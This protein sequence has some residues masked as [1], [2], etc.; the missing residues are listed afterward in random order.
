MSNL[1]PIYVYLIQNLETSRYKIG[2][3]KNPSKRIK[4]LQTGSGEE[5]K[6]IHTY[7][8]DNA[9]KI[10]TALHNRYSPQNTYGEWFEI[11]LLEE[12]VFINECTKID[13]NIQHLK[14][15]GNIFI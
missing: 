10:E 13:K 1:N 3:S 11:S 15:Q 8:S 9:R 6:L 14:D 4:Q 12:V 5:L 7:E 2:I